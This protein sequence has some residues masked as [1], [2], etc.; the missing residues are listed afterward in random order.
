MIDA[1]GQPQCVL[2]IGGGSDIASAL[3]DKWVDMRCQRVILAGRS[4]SVMEQVQSQLQSHSSAKVEIV[5]LDMADHESLAPLT[6]EVFER[7]PDIDMAV[8]A[9]G[10]LG[11]QAVDETDPKRIE[12]MFDVNATGPAIFLTACASEF[13]KKGAGTIV[14]LSS[15]AGEKVR[16]SNYVYGASKAATDSLSLAMSEALRGTGVNVL[17]VRP[18][19][20]STKMTQ[21]L[22]KAPL[23]TTKEKV[24]AD[25]IDA[26]AKKKTLIW[27]PKE[28]RWVMLAYKHIP[29][30]IARKIPF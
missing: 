18:G 24:A 15:V 1:L 9:A 25:I 30:M 3:V 6:A 19:F 10:Q 27:S 4:F 5:Y 7:F 26:L 17:V 14:V 2:I 12:Q 21:H 20:V 28:M 11:D 13:K 8:L 16:R 29:R 22:A 23:A